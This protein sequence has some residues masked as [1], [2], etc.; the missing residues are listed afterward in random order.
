MSSWQRNGIR[1]ALRKPV[2]LTLSHTRLYRHILRFDCIRS[3]VNMPCAKSTIA[4]LGLLMRRYSAHSGSS[5]ICLS[6]CALGL[7]SFSTSYGKSVMMQSTLASSIRFMPSRQSSLYILSISI[8]AVANWLSPS[9]RRAKPSLFFTHIS[10]VSGI[11]IFSTL[12]VRSASQRLFQSM[13]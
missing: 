2:V 8:I 9:G 6:H 1:L 3:A 11:S 10:P 4:A 7:P 13:R 5:G 12:T